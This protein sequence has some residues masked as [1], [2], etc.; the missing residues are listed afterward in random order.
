M[1]RRALRSNTSIRVAALVCAL[2]PLLMGPEVRAQEPLTVP[3]GLP[4]WTFNIPDKIQPSA[5]RPEGVVRAPGRAVETEMVGKSIFGSAAI[6]RKKYPTRPT[7]TIASVTEVVI[8]GRWM[9][10]TG[11]AMAMNSTLAKVAM[12]GPTATRTF[13]PCW[14]WLAPVG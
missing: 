13:W 11:S 8:T 1:I 3:A 14:T 2:A 10:R 6:G 7:S 4:D 5:V 9:Q 12:Q